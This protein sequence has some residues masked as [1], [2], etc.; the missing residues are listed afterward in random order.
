M[1]T[2]VRRG[3]AP[4]P[5]GRPAPKVRPT[6][7]GAIQ[8]E[9]I[10]IGRELL[11]G[12]IVD[13]NARNIARF[14]TQRGA[15]IRRIT[16]VDDN[17]RSISAALREALDRNPH[18]VIST[19]GLG[20]TDNDRTVAAMA[21]ALGLTVTL[22]SAAKSMVEAA[23]QRFAERRVIRSTGLTAARE[24]ICTLP[25][26]SVPVPNPV[27][28]SP[29]VLLRLPGGAAVLGLPGMPD[30]VLAVLAEA[31][32]ALGALAPDRQVARR[33]LESPTADE[34][35]LTPLLERFSAEF[36]SLWIESHPSGSRRR[37]SR[38]VISLEA[39]A[40]SGAEADRVVDTALKR[41]IALAAGSP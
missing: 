39:S 10:S 25:V 3:R 22:N 15:M 32:P 16:V 31:M 14:L 21:D 1:K 13:D 8:V 41:L 37:G 20:P 2:G 38:I 40:S 18:L 27:G 12:R 5:S 7:P 33:E 19:G 36:P 11:R 29:G 28:V 6:R 30:E 9:L 24:K 34:S 35:A 23:Y 4:R 26:G 17:E